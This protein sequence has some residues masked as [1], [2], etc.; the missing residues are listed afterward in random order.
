MATIKIQQNTA[1]TK[2]SVFDVSGNE[3]GI[4]TDEEVVRMAMRAESA[5]DDL[6][7]RGVCG[8]S[9][10]KLKAKIKTVDTFECCCGWKAQIVASAGRR[11]T[12]D[13]RIKLHNKICVHRE[14][15]TVT[16]VVYNS[17]GSCGHGVKKVKMN[18]GRE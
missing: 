2:K 3:S 16:D 15:K 7:T 6:R 9:N 4:F 11:Q 5:T 13:A 12:L 18:F 10:P 1:G 17:V 8:R 14:E